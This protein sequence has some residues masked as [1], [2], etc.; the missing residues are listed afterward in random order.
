MSFSV[1]ECSF[2]LEGVTVRYGNATALDAATLSIEPEEA[3]ALVGPSGA[4]KTTLLRLLNGTVSATSGRV[5]AHG[6][7]VAS[8]SP[9]E[10]RKLR[11]RIGFI[12]QDLSLVPNLRVIRNVMSGRIGRYSLA[13]SIRSILFATH[14]EAAEVYQI[15]QQVGIE[16]NLYDS[17]SRLSGGQQQ[18]VAIARALYQQPLSLLADEPVASVD[19]VRARD[20]V[21]LLVKICREQGLTLCMSLHNLELARDHFNRLIGL[22]DGRIIFDRSNENLTDD[23]FSLLYQLDQV[24][25]RKEGAR[26]YK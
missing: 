10:L 15:L 14:R 4:G 1:N 21:A 3:V 6:R 23:D 5:I 20:T 22:R 8:L 11:S 18:R 24:E 13:E 17:T 19:P 12:H 7:E 26:H 16:K 2:K 25:M 9:G